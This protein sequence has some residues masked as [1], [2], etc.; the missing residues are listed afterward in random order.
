M[1]FLMSSTQQTLGGLLNITP[2]SV[3][4]ACRLNTL[5]SSV[6]EECNKIFDCNI[7][8]SNITK[9]RHHIFLSPLNKKRQHAQALLSKRDAI[10]FQRVG[11]VCKKKKIMDEQM[12]ISSRK[13]RR[14]Q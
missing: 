2:T 1:R 6:G 7:T 13:Q 11:R 3:D 14:M 12:E 4:H 9:Q 8:P 5:V 10:E